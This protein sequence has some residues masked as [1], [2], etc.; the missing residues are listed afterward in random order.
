V[1]D[2][3]AKTA[4][5]PVTEV[6]TL[7][8]YVSPAVCQRVTGN[9]IRA[10]SVAPDASSD[11]AGGAFELPR[12]DDGD[13][14][15]SRAETHWSTGSILTA[16]CVSPPSPAEIVCRSSE[17]C[18]RSSRAR[19]RYLSTMRERPSLSPRDQISISSCMFVPN[20]TICYIDTEDRRVAST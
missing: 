15:S 13:M 18:V 10:G 3:H 2:N 9:T 4:G 5:W 11:P 7:N 16:G 20:G 1:S 14:H 17:D 8:T 19:E 6:Y 12:A